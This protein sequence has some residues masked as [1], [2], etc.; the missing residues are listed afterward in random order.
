[1]TTGKLANHVRSGACAKW[2]PRAFEGSTPFMDGHIV[3][4]GAPLT[5][6]EVEA[7]R[8]GWE[9]EKVS[10]ALTNNW[11]AQMAATDKDLSRHEEDH[12]EHDH[13]GV[14]TVPGLQGKY[15]AK[16]TLRG[17]KP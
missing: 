12:I 16:K 15:Q 13:G 5:E 3:W 7:G 14:T 11:K 10:A 1:M 6:A 8:A 4:N 17:Q 9:A 2:S